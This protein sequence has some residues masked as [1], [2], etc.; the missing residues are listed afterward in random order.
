MPSSSTLSEASIFSIECPCSLVRVRSSAA[1]KMPAEI[2]ACRGSAKWVVRPEGKIAATDGAAGT[3]ATAIELPLLPSWHP[4]AS[5][6]GTRIVHTDWW[7]SIWSARKCE[8]RTL[9]AR[10]RL[11]KLGAPGGQLARAPSRR[12]S[13]STTVQSVSLTA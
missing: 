13:Y 9:R 7:P 10:Y 4:M 3:L 8:I 12:L 11:T 2:P 1:R 6:T 5:A